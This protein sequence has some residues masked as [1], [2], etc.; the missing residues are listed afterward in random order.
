[1]DSTT[2]AVE[3]ETLTL[4]TGN[5]PAAEAAKPARKPRTKAPEATP[6]NVTRRED[7]LTI[8]DY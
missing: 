3:P 1:M 2:P 5:K 6:S 8:T 4:V 7:G